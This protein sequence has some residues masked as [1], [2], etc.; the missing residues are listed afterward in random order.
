MKK[1][2][3]SKLARR[4]L[5]ATVLVF[6]GM[7]FFNPSLANPPIAP[8]RDLMATNAPPAE[9]ATLLRQACYDCH[10]NETRW[11]WYAHVA[12]VSWW[13]THHLKE[14]RDEL[15]FS[16]WP[17]DDAYVAA[18]QLQTIANEVQSRKMPLPSYTWIGMH[19]EARLTEEQRGRILKWAEQT[20][21]R[22][23]AEAAK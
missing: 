21:Q 2:F 14:G 5:A 22:L 17:H 15:N 23:D 11:P 16:E 12:P 7:Q 10:S 19:P 6:A 18:N 9:V 13:I 1:I 8:G 20:I 4:L 3:K